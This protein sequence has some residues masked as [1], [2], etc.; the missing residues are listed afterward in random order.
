[1]MEEVV[2]YGTGEKAR[3]EGYTAA[4]K[5]GTAQK[6]DPATGRYAE[7]R[8]VASFAGFL[9]VEEPRAVIVVLV[10]EPSGDLYYA[11]DVAAPAFSRLGKEIMLQLGVPPSFGGHVLTASYTSAEDAA[12]RMAEIPT[13]T[14]GRTAE[15]ASL[16]DR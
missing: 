7:G 12:E 4:G 1:M 2:E 11:S 10:D 5:T 3:V 16:Y 14:P 9:P 13:R 8:Y 6:V 15:A